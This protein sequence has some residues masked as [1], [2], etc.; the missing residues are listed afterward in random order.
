LGAGF[1][2]FFV[3]DDWGGPS[4]TMSWGKVT[5]TDILEG[6]IRPKGFLIDFLFYLLLILAAVFVVSRIFQTPLNRNDVGWVMFISVSFIAGFLCAFLML[7]SSDL[8]L[9]EYHYS[10]TQTSTSPSPTTIESLPLMI[11][12][13]P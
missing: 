6:G 2:T 8:Y 1:P 5:L 4:P 9:R 10:T 13:A 7:V 12:P 3:C 11:T